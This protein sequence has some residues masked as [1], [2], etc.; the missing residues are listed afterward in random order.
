MRTREIHL[1]I[2]RT[3]LR[4]FLGVRLAYGASE[5]TELS[6]THSVKPRM[7]LGSVWRAECNGAAVPA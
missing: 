7:P 3:P 6:D 5:A 4:P 1:A 2:L